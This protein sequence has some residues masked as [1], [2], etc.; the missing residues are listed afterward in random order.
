MLAIR[1]ERDSMLQ[2]G[3]ASNRALLG[4]VFLTCVLQLATLYVPA[5]HPIFKTEPLSAVELVS[6]LALSAIV[7][8]AVE[9]EKALVRRG[10]LYRERSS[11][12]R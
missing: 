3:R 8:L 10:L 6:C 4:A 7:P 2:R 1:S 11:V 12:A 5:L 9:V